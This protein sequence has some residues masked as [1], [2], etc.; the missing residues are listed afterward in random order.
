MRELVVVYFLVVACVGSLGA[1]RFKSA[2][3]PQPSPPLGVEERGVGRG[4]FGRACE[5]SANNAT[6]RLRRLY[7]PSELGQFPRNNRQ[8]NQH[9]MKPMKTF[10]TRMAAFSLSNSC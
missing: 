10:Q 5:C 8:D 2:S 6:T 7:N 9:Q 4:R 3:S 1:L